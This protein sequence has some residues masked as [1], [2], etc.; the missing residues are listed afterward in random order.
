MDT[1]AYYFTYESKLCLKHLN[2][3]YPLNK[4]CRRS[5]VGVMSPKPNPSRTIRY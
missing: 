3:T 1:Y 5:K 2:I 4:L